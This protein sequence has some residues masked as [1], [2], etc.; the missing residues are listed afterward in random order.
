MRG[1][2][3]STNLL[4]GS[5]KAEKL[6]A[7][8]TKDQ[9]LEANHFGFAARQEAFE[10]KTVITEVY[11]PQKSMTESV[12]T[13]KLEDEQEDK[14]KNEFVFYMRTPYREGDKPTVLEHYKATEDQEESWS[15]IWMRDGEIHRDDKPARE[16]I[17]ADGDVIYREWVTN[18]KTQKTWVRKKI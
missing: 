2:N 6:E 13:A 18:G 16:T 4:F 10:T 3:Q 11:Y 14:E 9:W 15:L 5:R 17:N 7:S 8:L 12:F 1:S